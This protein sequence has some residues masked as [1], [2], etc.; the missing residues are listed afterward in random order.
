M[1]NKQTLDQ[2]INGQLAGS[3]EIR[4][5]H[6]GLKEFPLQILELADSLELLDLSGNQLSHL[7]DEIALLKKLKIVF[8]S[9]NCFEVF[10]DILSQLPHLEMVGFKANAIHTISEQ[11]LPP[12]LRWLILTQ[13]KITSLDWKSVV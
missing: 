5:T 13:N 4:L 8:F 9:D 12:Q 7:P 1:K 6:L 3:R 11:A 2:L 10:P